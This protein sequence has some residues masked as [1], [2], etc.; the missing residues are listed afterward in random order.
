MMMKES[1]LIN[2]FPY[3]MKSDRARPV[4]LLINRKSKMYHSRSFVFF[5]DISVVPA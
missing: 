4:H 5:L 3:I 1:R 2:I